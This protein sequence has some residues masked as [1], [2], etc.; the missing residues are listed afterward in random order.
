MLITSLTKQGQ[1]VVGN[2]N[3]ISR[4]LTCLQVEL[5]ILLE[6]KVQARDS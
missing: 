2:L 5:K 3:I 6:R 4:H 1:G